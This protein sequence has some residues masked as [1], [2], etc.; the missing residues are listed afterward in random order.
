[1]QAFPNNPLLLGLQRGPVRLLPDLLDPSG[2]RFQ[3][4]STPNRDVHHRRHDLRLVPFFS[5]RVVKRSADEQFF[6][7]IG[8]L[9]D[10]AMLGLMTSFVLT[11][12]FMDDFWLWLGELGTV[13]LVIRSGLQLQRIYRVV[14]QA[15]EVHM[16]QGMGEISLNDIDL[17][18][19]IGREDAAK[20][21]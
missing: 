15:R 1:M 2:P 9:V 7:R 8:N 13:L 4:E 18:E 10:L 5:Y 17:G 20:A 21:H 16:L 12:L 14:K 3:I 11:E 6:S 19:E